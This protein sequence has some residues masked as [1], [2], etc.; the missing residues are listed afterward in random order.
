[1]IGG[2]WVF[3]LEVLVCVGG[4]WPG[5]RERERGVGVEKEAMRIGC[6]ERD[7]PQEM[8]KCFLRPLRI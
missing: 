8:K 5:E 4:G 7:V 1:M 2:F 3:F 6:L